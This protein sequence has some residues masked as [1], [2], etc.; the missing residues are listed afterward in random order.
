[1]AEQD[2][3]IR[4]ASLEN[5]FLRNKDLINQNLL[6]EITVIG[7]GGIGSTVVTLLA[8]MGWDKIIGWD[9]DKL[10]TH[11][12]SSTTYPTRFVGLPKV[13]TA[14]EIVIG[15]SA[16]QT[17]FICGDGKWSSKEGIGPKV[18]TCLDNMD[19]RMEAYE[20]W[21]NADHPVEKSNRFFIDLRMSALSLEMITITHRPGG[22]INHENK[23]FDEIYES[24]WVPDSQ[25]EPAPC[26]MKH[27]IFAS[28]IIGG[29]GVN[30]VF[31]CVANKPYYSYI[32][33]GLLPLNLEKDNLVKTYNEWSI[34]GYKSP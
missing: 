30:Q 31:N 32:W 17:K 4:M 23:N 20:T 33:A 24:H 8:I 25:I 18:I 2:I 26:T 21:V 3:G 5:R 16:A 27:T 22:F 28:S 19:T 1:M 13:K 11:N 12:L 6:D 15:H 9:D 10:E 14:H 7:L 34:N 29:L